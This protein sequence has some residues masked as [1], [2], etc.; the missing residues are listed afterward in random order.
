MFAPNDEKAHKN[1]LLCIRPRVIF[2]YGM[3]RKKILYIK[4]KKIKGIGL[5][6][7]I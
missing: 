5:L 3:G 4:F 6:D 1:G 7:G 2:V